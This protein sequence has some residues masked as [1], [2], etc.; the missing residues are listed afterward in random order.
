MSSGHRAIEASAGRPREYGAPRT[1]IVKS[2]GMANLQ[3][4]SG[5]FSTALVVP[6]FAGQV[7]VIKPKDKGPLADSDGATDG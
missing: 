4:H 5:N 3:T 2:I 1:P 6:G 7:G